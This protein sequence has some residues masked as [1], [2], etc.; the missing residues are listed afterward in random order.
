[1]RRVGLTTTVPV[2][3]ILAAG[4]VPVDLN[5]LFIAHPERGEFIRRAEDQGFPVNLCAWIKGIYGAALE[6]GIKE[7]VG[8]THGDCSSTEKLMEVFKLR[9]IQPIPFA[10]P[11]DRDPKMMEREIARLMEYFE[12]GQAALDDVCR[13]LARIRRK[14]VRLD[15]LTWNEGLVSGRENAD[16]L[17]SA[18]DF[19]GD[20]VKFETELD[21]F[22]EQAE[23]RPPLPARVQLGIVGVPAIH[24][25]LYEVLEQLGG[26]VVFNEVQRQFAMIEQSS[27]LI[28][29]YLRYT[30]PYDTF[31]RLVDIVRQ[32]GRRDIV[33]VI[34][35]AQTF[36]HRQIEGI[37]LRERM[38]MPV[39]TIEGDRP[40]PIDQ[41]T[42]TR[43]EAFMEMLGEA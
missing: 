40:G 37:I 9:G 41:Q 12:V 19:R 34:H 18:S 20:P 15:D 13:M 14:L 27:S 8:V 26:T 30:Y 24:D 6:D 25:D 23:T 32:A 38:S 36:C 2:E 1:M 10:F 33:G 29:Q 3:V 22:L 5:N 35:Y 31:G 4:A 7:V 43:I 21:E 11:L 28:D 39:L 17:V 16:W 42:R